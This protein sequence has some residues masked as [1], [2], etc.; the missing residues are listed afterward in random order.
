MEERTTV[1]GAT[2][3]NSTPFPKSGK[4]KQSRSN[5]K[6]E[7]EKEGEGGRDERWIS[8]RSEGGI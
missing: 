4:A 6:V 1:G 3:F 2:S 5:V 7:V 8:L